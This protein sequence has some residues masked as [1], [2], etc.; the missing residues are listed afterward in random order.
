[1]ENPMNDDLAQRSPDLHWPDGFSPD[2]ADL[3]AHNE[4]VIDAPCATVWQHLIEAEQWPQWYPYSQDVLILN[5][6]TG[7][8]REDSRFQWRTFGIDVISE[9][10]E[11]VPDSRIGWYGR[12][13]GLTSYHTWRLLDAPNCCHVVMEEAAKG[14]VAVALRDADPDGMHKGH[15]LWNSRLKERAEG[16]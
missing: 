7:V 1:M 3:F 11:F 5:N 2:D 10:F 9:V 4:I 6:R 14:R 16:R 8:L 12:A 13:P 15:D